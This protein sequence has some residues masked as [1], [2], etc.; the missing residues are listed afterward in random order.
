MQ[1]W[2]LVAPLSNQHVW[3]RDHAELRIA[4]TILIRRIVLSTTFLF[5]EGFGPWEMNL[6]LWQG[7]Q[8]MIVPICCR[9][10]D[11]IVG[12]RICTMTQLVHFCSSFHRCN[13]TPLV[14]PN[15][16]VL[17]TCGR[18]IDIRMDGWN[19]GRQKKLVL[20]GH[21]CRSGLHMPFRNSDKW[22]MKIILIRPSG[23]RD[24]RLT[25]NPGKI[26][27]HVVMSC[28]KLIRTVMGIIRF[29]TG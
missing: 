14:S 13:S 12:A 9:S 29:V 1:H 10:G 18:A 5:M 4:D 3:A 27:P 19:K 21:N 17:L 25:L 26:V 28:Y 6:G 23:S 22:Y 8:K 7:Q 24:Y 11:D 16:T 20:F 2:A 15:G